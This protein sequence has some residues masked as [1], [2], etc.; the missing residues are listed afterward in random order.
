M[1]Q[2]CEMEEDEEG[3]LQSMEQTHGHEGSIRFVVCGL[4]VDDDSDAYFMATSR[5]QIGLEIINLSC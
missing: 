3:A 5:Q 2:P 1:R 4:L